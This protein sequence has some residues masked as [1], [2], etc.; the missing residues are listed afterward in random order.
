VRQNLILLFRPGTLIADI[1]SCYYLFLKKQLSYVL[2]RV[3]NNYV[4]NK[5]YLFF[6]I[7][8]IFID[9]FRHE[10]KNTHL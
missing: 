7:Q 9:I 10:L 2:L 4:I 1:F 3:G 6:L 8:E 5:L